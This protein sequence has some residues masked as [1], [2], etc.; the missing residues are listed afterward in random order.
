GSLSA[1]RLISITGVYKPFSVAG[2]TI[3]LLAMLC[4]TQVHAGTP[5]VL[6]GALMLVQGFAV[7]LGQQAPIIG[8]QNSAPKADIGAAS[9]AVTL[10]RMGGAAIAISVYGAIVT[11]SLKGVAVT[12]PGVG[13]IEELTPKM[14]SELPAASQT[15]VA[16]LY[17]DAFTPLFFAAAATAAIG[18]AAALM[19]K[20]VR[21][22]SATPAA[23]PA[24]SAGE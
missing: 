9:G 4:F 23:K 15:A 22:P 8:V 12:I 17:S 21:L 19:L 7:G 10:T 5:L 11:S 24:E 2:L 20:P 14:L 16:A 13:R 3:N 18:L 1:G 6:I